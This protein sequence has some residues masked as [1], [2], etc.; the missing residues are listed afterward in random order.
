MNRP[1][2]LLFKKCKECNTLY[3]ISNFHKQ[4]LGKYGVRNICKKCRIKFNAEHKEERKEYNKKYRED[5]HDK[6]L[7][8][9][10][11][12]KEKRNKQSKEWRENNKEHVKEYNKIY[13]KDN[14]EKRNK[15]SK[16]WRENNPEKVFNYNNERRFKE[17]NQGRGITKEQWFEMM[18]FFNWKCAYSG[19]KMERNNTINGRTIDHIVALDN[20]GEH[21]IW[22]VIPMK[23]GYNASKYTSDM[24]E[25]YL[26]QEY[27]DI[28]RLTRIYEWRIYAYWKWKE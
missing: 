14:F 28:D 8:Y 5:N 7:E 12:H 9:N 10:K 6:F 23:R 2:H 20:G 16:E 13:R 11:I 25:W 15:Q 22:N 21:E 18:E 17:E 24:L 19:E 3:H 26:E 1:K 27:F 4:K